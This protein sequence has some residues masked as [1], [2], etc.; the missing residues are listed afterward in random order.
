MIRWTGLAPWEFEFPFPG[1][2]TSTCL[3]GREK[4]ESLRAAS[5][6]HTHLYHE[7]KVCVLKLPLVTWRE[8]V[9][10]LEIFV[11]NPPQAVG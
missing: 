7:T 1:S 8:S 10:R 9:R 11:V 2:L 6:G 3:G 4:N 5:S